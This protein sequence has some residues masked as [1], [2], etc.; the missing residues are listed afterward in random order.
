MCLEITKVSG[1]FSHDVSHAN[2]RGDKRSI[3]IVVCGV[4]RPENVQRSNWIML[5]LYNV[6]MCA[7]VRL[8]Q[9][10]VSQF[11]CMRIA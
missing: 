7:P 6:E 4:Y 1:S 8:M 9:C 11:L 3:R 5:M 2:N 10:Y